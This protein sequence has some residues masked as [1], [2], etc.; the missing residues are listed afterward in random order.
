[1]SAAVAFTDG[2]MRQ[3]DA[4]GTPSAVLTALDA[5][6]PEKIARAVNDLTRSV[7]EQARAFTPRVIF[8]RDVT[9]TGTGLVKYRF[10]HGFRGLVNWYVARWSSAAGG[11]SLVEDASTTADTL[12]LVSYIAGTLTLRV[13][14][15]G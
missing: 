11:H 3:L 4:K 13:E 15:A 14:E 5:Q 7:A 9:V 2:R 12:V 10:Q 8:H 6:E 1:M